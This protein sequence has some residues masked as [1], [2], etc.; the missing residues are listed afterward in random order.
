MGARRWLSARQR[1]GQR[2]PPLAGRVE[3]RRVVNVSTGG[4]GEEGAHMGRKDCE[5]EMDRTIARGKERRV[6]D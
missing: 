5:E 1:P 2:R 4:V 3:K 6:R